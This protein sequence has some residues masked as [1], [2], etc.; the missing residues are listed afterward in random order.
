MEGRKLLE[1]GLIW[2]IG[3]GLSVDIWKD[4]WIPSI[5]GF[6]VQSLRQAW[7]P[8]FKVAHL[9]NHNP[10]RWN[11]ELIRVL[12]QDNEANAIPEIPLDKGDCNDSLMWFFDYHGC[13]S[14]KDAYKKGWNKT[15]ENYIHNGRTGYEHFNL[16]CNSKNL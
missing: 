13:F 14:V 16:L 5:E 12:F 7:C 1:L 11:E 8:L 15:I 4:P 9:M 2:R 10:K 3:N 6:K